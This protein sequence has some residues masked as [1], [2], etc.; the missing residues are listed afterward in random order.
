[1][2][3]SERLFILKQEC[4]CEGQSALSNGNIHQSKGEKRE[5]FEIK[6]IQ[7]IF[8]SKDGSF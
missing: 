7:I 8:I 1:L 3:K 5:E 6:N 4:A 2:N